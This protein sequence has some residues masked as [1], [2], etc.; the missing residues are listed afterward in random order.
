MAAAASL[1][2]YD[3]VE[4][5]VWNAATGTLTQAQKDALIAQQV[6]GVTQASGPG[7]TVDTSAIAAQAQKDV[8]NVLT[9]N[10]ADPSQASLFNN[11]GLDSIFQKAGWVIAI[12]AGA[13]LLYFIVEA[14]YAFRG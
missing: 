5:F 10:K 12:V 4:G 7:A 6:Q 11:P 8:T 2:W 13:A 14:Y 9:L 1:P 3:E